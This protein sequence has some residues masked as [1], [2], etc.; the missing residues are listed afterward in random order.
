MHDACWVCSQ[1]VRT[2]NCKLPKQKRGCQLR[3]VCLG[4]RST[5]SQQRTFSLILNKSD[6]HQRAPAIRHLI[7]NSNTISC[8]ECNAAA[9]R[10]PLLH[11][12]CQA[13]EAESELWLQCPAQPSTCGCGGYTPADL[14]N[15]F[16]G[17]GVPTTVRRRSFFMP[18]RPS[19][20]QQQQ[21]MP[22]QTCLCDSCAIRRTCSARQCL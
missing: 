18:A 4:T 8:K 13:L 17:R 1:G 6:P 7:K 12:L 2:A 22:C 14:S 21:Q 19:L 16:A 5:Q 20:Q 11:T 3:C 15:L 10:K 9:A